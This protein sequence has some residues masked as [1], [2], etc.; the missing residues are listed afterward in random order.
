MAF[1]NF[2]PTPVPDP[3]TGNLAFIPATSLPFQALRGAGQFYE[4]NIQVYSPDQFYYGQ[5]QQIQ[6]I[7]GVEFVGINPQSLIDWE[8]YIQNLQAG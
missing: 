2:V 1:Y 8:L 5:E 6:G 3:Q 7:E 4:T